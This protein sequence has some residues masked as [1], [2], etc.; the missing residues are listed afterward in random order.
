M[1]KKD[2]Q[3]ENILDTIYGA[4]IIGENTAE[5]I[6]EEL[7][8]EGYCK[9]KEVLNEFIKNAEKKF[10]ERR[11]YSENDREAFTEDYVMS[12]LKNIVSNMSSK[13]YVNYSNGSKNTSYQRGYQPKYGG[14]SKMKKTIKTS[15]PNIKV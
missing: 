14:A 13:I 7:Y 1:N 15:P 6:A 8:N 9:R 5:T 11:M 2:R 4:V 10:T 3:I 12:V